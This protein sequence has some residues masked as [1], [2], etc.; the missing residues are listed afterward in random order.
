VS[1]LARSANA[2][3]TLSDQIRIATENTALADADR[4]PDRLRRI[5]QLRRSLNRSSWQALIGMQNGSGDA[6]FHH[7]REARRPARATRRYT[8]DRRSPRRKRLV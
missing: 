3:Q 6:A 1:G 5:D 7:R 2:A 4:E 8:G